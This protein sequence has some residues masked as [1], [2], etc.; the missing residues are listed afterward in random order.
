MHV[1]NRDDNLVSR[2][3]PIAKQKPERTDSVMQ[4]KAGKRVECNSCGV[5]HVQIVCMC[6]FVDRR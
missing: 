3:L 1:E 5:Q 4:L 2:S 6:M